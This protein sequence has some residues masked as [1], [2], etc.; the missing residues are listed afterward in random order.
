MKRGNWWAGPSEADVTRVRHLALE[1]GPSEI[2][3]REGISRRTVYRWLEAPRFRCQ[4]CGTS[5]K[6]TIEAWEHAFGDPR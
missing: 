6:T 4:H 3:L 1:M 5:F 2:A